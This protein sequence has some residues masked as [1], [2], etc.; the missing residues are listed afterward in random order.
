MYFR[1]VTLDF[2]FENKCW[3]FLH[4]CG[5]ILSFGLLQKDVGEA[6]YNGLLEKK[7]TAVIRLQRKVRVSVH[8]NFKMMVCHYS[9]LCI[10]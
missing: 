4:Q 5:S 10:N 8:Y 1:C 6:K 3:P 7:W 9:T 2:L